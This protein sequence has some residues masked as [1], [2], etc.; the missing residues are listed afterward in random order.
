MATLTVFKPFNMETFSIWSSLSYPIAT[1]THIRVTGSGGRIQDFF[2][3][4]FKFVGDDDV[5]AGRLQ[6]T[7]YTL[8]GVQQWEVTGLNHSAV[9]IDNYL[10]ASN[11]QALFS[12]VFSGKDTLKGS[13]GRDV[14]NGY[15]N[16]DTL[17]GNGGNDKLLG[18][19]GND[20]LNGGAGDDTLNGDAENDILNGDAGEDTLNGGTG[21]DTLKG[22]DANDKLDGG[23][24]N[25]TL[26][27][28]AGTDNILGG[29]GYDII[30]WDAKDTI[31]GGG[32]GDPAQGGYPYLD[33]LHIKKDDAH[34]NLV[35]NTRIKDIEGVTFKGDDQKLTL[36]AESVIAISSDNGFSIDGRAGTLVVTDAGEWMEDGEETL[37]GIHYWVYVHGDNATLYVTDAI[38]ANSNLALPI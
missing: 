1:P 15:G 35:G 2:G 3:T 7:V 5:S 10:D 24:G 20:K 9:T 14:L 28:G 12:F 33:I 36:D 32:G 8:N 38:L 23:V 26:D 29:S 34:L 30:V 11:E 37:N 4:G 17:N 13:S 19:F 31:D 18:G 6:S 16:D 27:G 22:G 25:D 21:N